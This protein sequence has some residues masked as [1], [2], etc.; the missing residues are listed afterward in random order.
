MTCNTSLRQVNW[1][2][3]TAIATSILAVG[4]VRGDA[5]VSRLRRSSGL[6][7]TRAIAG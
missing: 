4:L 5:R 7:G 6:V 3:V 2:E 1:A